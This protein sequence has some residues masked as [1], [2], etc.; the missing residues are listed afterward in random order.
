MSK[1]LSRV[2]NSGRFVSGTYLKKNGE[3]TTFHGRAGVRKYRKGGKSSLNPNNFLIWDLRRK[4]YMAI[5][6]Q[7]ILSFKGDG[8]FI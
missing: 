8:L 2:F 3:V 1:E 7:N 6:P 5:V 4:R